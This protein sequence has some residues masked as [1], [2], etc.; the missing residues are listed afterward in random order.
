MAGF[1]DRGKFSLKRERRTH[2]G[3]KKARR[4]ACAPSSKKEAA[5]RD[6]HPGAKNGR[7]L[8]RKRL[9]RSSGL[10]VWQRG[11]ESIER[12]SCHP[13][14]PPWQAEQLFGDGLGRRGPSP[15]RLWRGG[16]AVRKADGKPRQPHGPSGRRRSG[17]Y[18][19][20]AAYRGSKDRG[21]CLG[22]EGSG[23]EK[24]WPSP[25]PLLRRFH[26]LGRHGENSAGSA[27]SGFAEHLPAR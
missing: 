18:R 16:A 19:G 2:P 15:A 17:A 25:F 9:Q 1:Q 13:A 23:W 21:R 27:R 5:R 22:R 20:F 12:V 24:A 3:R 7:R 14:G 6:R 10:R 4:T 8:R 11:R 26:R